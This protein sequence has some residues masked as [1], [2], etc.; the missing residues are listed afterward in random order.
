MAGLQS[1]EVDKHQNPG[2]VIAMRCRL[3]RENKLIVRQAD[4]YCIVCC[5]EFVSRSGTSVI[6]YNDLHSKCVF[7]M[8]LENISLCST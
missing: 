1:E 4:C 6:L 5:V 8:F 3:T 7:S 2:D